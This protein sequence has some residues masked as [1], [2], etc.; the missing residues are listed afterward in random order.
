MTGFY[1]KSP[2]LFN[3]KDLTECSTL[4][5]HCYNFI[6]SGESIFVNVLSLRKI[7]IFY[8]TDLTSLN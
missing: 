6:N 1:L 8:R 5:I 2:I 4:P 3:K 7:G